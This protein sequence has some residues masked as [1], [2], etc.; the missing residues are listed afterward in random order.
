MPIKQISLRGISRAPSDRMTNDGGCAESLNVHL[1]ENELSPTLPPED[2]TEREGLPGAEYGLKYDILYYHKTN[3]YANYICKYGNQVGVWEKSDSEFFIPKE[4]QGY[5]WF[6]DYS[7]VEL[8]EEAD[9]DGYLHVMIEKSDD[10]IDYDNI[11]FVI[12]DESGSYYALEDIVGGDETSVEYR[13]HN[14]GGKLDKNFEIKAFLTLND[15]EA[16][17]DVTSIGNTIV[18]VISERMF[19][20]LWQDGKYK[21]LGE[22]IPEPKIEFQCKGVDKYCNV[23]LAKKYIYTAYWKE[24]EEVEDDTGDAKKPNLIKEM[25]PTAWILA[26]NGYKNN[27]Y[28]FPPDDEYEDSKNSIDYIISGEN[29]L[30]E[31]LKTMKEVL[32]NMWESLSEYRTKMRKRGCFIAPVLVRYA[33]RLYNGDY[34]YA[35]APILLGAGQ[36][37]S[38]SMHGVQDIYHYLGSNMFYYGKHLYQTYFYATSSNVY[39]AFA[40]SAVVNYDMWTDIVDSIDIFMST[41]LGIP[42]STD[43]IDHVAKLNQDNRTEKV[44]TL[45]RQDMTFSFSY[46]AEHLTGDGYVEKKILEA[47]N[48]YKIASFK[49]NGLHSLYASYNLLSDKDLFEQTQLVLKEELQDPKD[50][51]LSYR[52]GTMITYNNRIISSHNH[53]TLNPGNYW[54]TT[55]C[56][57]EE[58]ESAYDTNKDAEAYYLKFHIRNS[59]GQEVTVLGRN[60]KG[61]NNLNLRYSRDVPKS[62]TETEETFTAYSKA[63]GVIFHPDSRCYQV[64]VAIFK[65]NGSGIYKEVPMTPHPGLNCSYA[66]MGLGKTLKECIASTAQ[67]KTLRWLWRYFLTEN[68]SYSSFNKLMISNTNNVFQFSSQVGSFSGLI[69]GI[70]TTTKALSTGQ[71]GQFPLY[72]FTEDGIFAMTI[73]TDGSFGSSTPLSREVALD[74]KVFPIDQA[75]VFITEKGVMMLQG[76]DIMELSPNMNGKHW[77]IEDDAKDVI[78][79]KTQYGNLLESLV[80]NTPFM[81]FMKQATCCYDYT[82]KR[83]VFFNGSCDYQY[84]YMLPTGTWHKYRQ[85]AALPYHLDSAINSYPDCLISGTD[86]STD[87]TVLLNLSTPLDVER[88]D[89]IQSVIATRPMDLDNPDILKTVNHLKIRGQYQRYDEDGK[90][91]VSYMIFGSQDGIHFHRLKSLRG[92]SWKLFRVI[93]LSSLTPTERLSWIDIDYETRFTN[94]L[95]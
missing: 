21:G 64:D 33:L 60:C 57:H 61:A 8:T 89:E 25:D 52:P 38:V 15:G 83:L 17:S 77:V 86:T 46:G 90:P 87:T 53:L 26:I 31:Y 3:N 94:K 80:D 5:N 72:V 20:V 6:K 10:S 55:A 59:E 62:E 51:G 65:S 43:D 1:D 91:R 58:N 22:K 69:R 9:A 42:S 68:S 49:C 50:N 11:D 73:N 78:S 56:P 27:A 34:I 32:P 14:Y 82:G 74:G 13:V 45:S 79:S 23:S 76:S 48:F 18:F 44:Y 81:A 54:L 29:T 84:V 24:M 95:R 39:E 66:Y 35:S 19:Y 28:E 71:F 75:I 16:V 47:T 88:T 92:K 12:T 67:S 93:V 7:K 41:D 4:L 40:K 36:D 63:Y 30:D 70:A 2:I 85:N 37:S